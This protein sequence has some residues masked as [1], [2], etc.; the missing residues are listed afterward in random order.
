MGYTQSFVASRR[1][2]RRGLGR[3]P[4]LA[5]SLGCLTLSW[6]AESW[7]VGPPCRVGRW[8]WAPSGASPQTPSGRVGIRCSSRVGFGWAVA[9]SPARCWPR[10]RRDCVSCPGLASGKPWLRLPTEVALGQVVIAYPTRG[11]PRTSRDLGPLC[12]GKV[13]SV[14]PYDPFLLKRLGTLGLWSGYP[15]L[16]YPTVAPEPSCGFLAK[17]QKPECAQA[18][19]YDIAPEPRVIRWGLL[20]GLFGSWWSHRPVFCQPLL[21]S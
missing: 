7:L 5:D 15:L 19:Q 3:S 17:G 21:T 2:T 14:F 10:T 9:A 11:W 1:L 8:N 6:S 12:L 4:H 13:E 20:G 16:W 18:H